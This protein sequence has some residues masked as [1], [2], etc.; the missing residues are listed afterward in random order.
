DGRDD[1]RLTFREAQ[2]RPLSQHRGDHRREWR[3]ARQIPQDACSGRP[4]I[5]REVLFRARRSWISCVAYIARQDRRL[6]LLG[7]MVSGSGATNGIARCGNY[8]LSHRNTVAA[9]GKEG[10]RRSATRRLG[11][12]P[13]W[14]RN[15][16]WL[17]R[18]GAKPRGT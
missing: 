8:F 18:G 1:Y 7:P 3:I 13:A 12:D 9:L 16:E 4:A 10:V 14:S 11:N 2:C 6:H 17:L 15:R 5:S